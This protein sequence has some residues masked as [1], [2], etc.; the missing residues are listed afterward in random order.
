M[1]WDEYHPVGGIISGNDPP[2]VTKPQVPGWVEQLRSKLFK[3]RWV[4]APKW[5]AVS[6]SEWLTLCHKTLGITEKRTLWQQIG[7]DI[8][9]IDTRL[10]MTNWI[11]DL[12]TEPTL[13]MFITFSHVSSISASFERIHRPASLDLQMLWQQSWCLSLVPQ[14]QGHFDI[15]QPWD[16]QNQS[17][18]SKIPWLTHSSWVVTSCGPEIGILM[19]LFCLE[20]SWHPLPSIPQVLEMLRRTPRCRALVQE[21]RTQQQ[22]WPHNMTP[23]KG[24]REGFKTEYPK[25]IAGLLNSKQKTVVP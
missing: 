2:V 17:K 9:S 3:R 23:R 6:L 4:S 12:V 25:K 13:L 20:N 22:P 15:T 10:G 18:R 24:W 19:D 14:L 21:K 16:G 1:I 7:N 8:S 5:C 11:P